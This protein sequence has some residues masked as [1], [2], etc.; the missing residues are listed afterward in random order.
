MPAMAIHDSA[1]KLIKD[2]WYAEP[3]I[4]E[5]YLFPSSDEIRIVHLDENSPTLQ[6]GEKVA[7]F[8]FRASP[9]SG[10]THRVAV[11]II[12]PVDK[13]QRQPP[14]GWGDWADAERLNPGN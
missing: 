12:N 1:T 4:K 6:E 7:P 14:N 10:L 9:D 8:Y 11:V 3:G 2:N 13:S 5:T